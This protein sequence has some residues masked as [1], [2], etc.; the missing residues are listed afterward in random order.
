MWE[1]HLTEMHCGN[2]ENLPGP[3]H[4]AGEAACIPWTPSPREDGWIHASG[5]SDR[6][7]LTL[8]APFSLL[9]PH[10][11]RCG[12]VS[13]LFTRLFLQDLALYNEFTI[14]D[15]LVFFG[16]IHGLTSKDTQARMDFLIDFLDLPQKSSLVRN[17]RLGCSFDSRP[18]LGCPLGLLSE[19]RSRC[20]SSETP[21][22]LLHSINLH[23]QANVIAISLTGAYKM[24]QL[25]VI[26]WQ[27]KVG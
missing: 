3:H 27:T 21:A 6:L 4:R 9:G 12:D 17:L 2:S 24:L 26:T 22:A 25:C 23:L 11:G 13:A 5:A 10:G 20:S 1:D 14:S 18:C 16:R 19:H 8:Q 7:N 15:T